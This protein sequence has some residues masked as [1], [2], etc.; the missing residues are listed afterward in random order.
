MNHFKK[1]GRQSR[2]T[3]P[4]AMALI[5]TDFFTWQIITEALKF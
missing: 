3:V 1:R 4:L 2:A 5:G